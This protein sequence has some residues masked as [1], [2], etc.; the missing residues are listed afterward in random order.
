MDVATDE[1][2]QHLEQAVKYIGSG[3][4]K[5]HPADYGFQRTH[6]RPTKSL[7]DLER[8]VLLDEAK[9]HIKNGIRYGL[10]S[11]I[12]EDGFQNIFGT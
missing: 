7:C 6:P 11:E 2:K 10:F 3:H 12:R 5:R 8:T 1:I 9:S 4:H